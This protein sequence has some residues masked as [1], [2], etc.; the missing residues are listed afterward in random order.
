M[1][2]V[3]VFGR[4]LNRTTFKRG[5]P[6]I[7]FRITRDGQYDLENKRLCNIAAA[8]EDNDAVNLTLLTNKLSDTIKLLQEGLDGLKIRLLNVTNALRIDAEHAQKLITDQQT[9][10]DSRLTRIELAYANTVK[11]LKAARE[12]KARKDNE[13]QTSA[14]SRAA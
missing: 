12:K 6:G 7:G 14:G 11:R 3:D 2:S 9:Q 10:L 8:E 4:S 1:M 5:P 13:Q